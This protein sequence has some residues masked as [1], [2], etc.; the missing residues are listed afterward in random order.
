MLCLL[1]PF[2]LLLLLV[3]AHRYQISTRKVPEDACVG[4]NQL[5]TMGGSI[6]T[7]IFFFLHLSTHLLPEENAFRER[8]PLINTDW[9][10]ILTPFFSDDGP[11]SEDAWSPIRSNHKY[12]TFPSASLILCRPLTRSYSPK[13][14]SAGSHHHSHHCYAYTNYYI[15]ALET[16]NK[17]LD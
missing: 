3:A 16:Q 10:S 1:P 2:S 17:L 6:N 4:R 13:M 7:C 9:Q 12:D 14:Q 5:V 11:L 15:V 8:N